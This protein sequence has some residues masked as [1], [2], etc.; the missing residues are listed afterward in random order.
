MATSI[1]EAS[2]PHVRSASAMSSSL[3]PTSSAFRWYA[4]AVSMKVMPSSSAAW[5]VLIERSRSGRPS[6]DMGMPPRPMAET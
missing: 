4:S 6:I 3:W 2:P 5:M 1:V